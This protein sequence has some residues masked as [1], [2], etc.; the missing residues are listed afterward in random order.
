MI[1]S[2]KIIAMLMLMLTLFSSFSNVVMATEINSASLNKGADCGY[3]LQFWD[4]NRN[5]WSYIICT[6]V[7]YNRNGVEYPAY[8]LN[9][10]VPRSRGKRRIFCKYK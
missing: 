9:K 2:K 6:Y 3:H 1:K 4:T 5:L 10:E 8:C 7:T